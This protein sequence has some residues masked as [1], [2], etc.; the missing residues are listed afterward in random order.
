MNTHYDEQRITLDT[1]L[2]DFK[3]NYTPMFDL[4]EKEKHKKMTKR[5]NVAKRTALNVRALPTMNSRIVATLKHNTKVKV[6]E[7]EHDEF[8]KVETDD[9]IIGY[10]CKQYIR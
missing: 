8:Y 6:V 10:C 2:K 7:F 3:S 4:P 1:T 9:G 5:V